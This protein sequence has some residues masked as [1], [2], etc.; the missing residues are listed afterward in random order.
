MSLSSSTIT[1]WK[2]HIRTGATVAQ[3]PEPVSH[4]YRIRVPKCHTPTAATVSNIYRDCTE[5]RAA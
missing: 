3:E 4:R 5:R 1:C 2:C